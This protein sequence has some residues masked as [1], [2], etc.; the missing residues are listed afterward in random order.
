[1]ENRDLHT[2]DQLDLKIE[3]GKLKINNT[4][5]ISEIQCPHYSEVLTW[6]EAECNKLTKL[7]HEK[8]KQGTTIQVESSTFQGYTAE[9]ATIEDINELYKAMRLMHTTARH[10]TCSFRLPGKNFV[11]FQDSCDD[12]EWG[13]GRHILNAMK[14][15][16][17][18]FR[19]IFITR[20]YNG[21]HVG[22]CTF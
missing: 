3:K 15:T 22:G 19:V 16:D 13:A 17:M 4:E 2:L 18:Y 11:K 9:I 5:F 10:I 7:Y 20:H 1:M 14:S 21:K 6:N 8:I 12:G